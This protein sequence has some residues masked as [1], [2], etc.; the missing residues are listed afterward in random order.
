MHRAAAAAVDASSP[1]PVPAPATGPGHAEQLARYRTGL[2]V[3]ATATGAYLLWLMLGV[4]SDRLRVAV[5]DL[6]FVAAPAAAGWACLL[7]HRLRAGRHTAW[8]WL[9]AGCWTWALGSV[10]FAVYE[11]GLG[12]RTPFPSWADVGY[13]GYAVP[14]AIAIIRFP[15]ADGT[16]WARWRTAL[17]GVVIAGSLLL[18]SLVWVLEPVL[19][20]DISPFTRLDALSYP[21]VDVAVV[22][23]VMTQGLMLPH[24]RRHV[25]VPMSG[26]LLALALTDSIYVAQ[27]FGD[28]F[29]PGS[30]LDVGWLI[31]FVMVGLAALA[32]VAAPDRPGP[33]AYGEPAPMV[34]QLIPYAAVAVALTALLSDP[35]ALGS[36]GTLVA[37]VGGVL[38][39]AVVVRQVVVAAD[40]TAVARTLGD[41][42]ERRTVELRHREQWW[43]DLVQNLSDV[44]VVINADGGMRYCSPSAATTLGPWTSEAQTA[45]ELQAHIHP[46]DVQAVLDTV[47]PV[48]DGRARH[49]FVECRVEKA[50]GSWGWFEIT[51][52]G[53]LTEQ[54]L[55]G[56]VLTLHDVSERR[57]LTDQLTHEAYHDALTGLPNRALLMR[58]IEQVLEDHAGERSALL[59]IDLDDFKVI[60]DRHGHASGD[61]VLEVIGR[62][63]KNAVRPEDT[64]ARLGGDEF[65]LLMRGSTS[66]VRATADRLIEQIG[67]PVVAGGRRFLVRASVGVVFAGEDEL[68]NAHSMLSHADIALYEAKAK[69]KGGVVF[70]EGH[71][72]DAAAKQVHLREQ[73]AQPDLSQ[74]SVVYQP[75]VD[76]TTGWMRGVECLLRW[77][78][79]DLGSVPPDDFIPMAEAGGSIHV[80]G[81]Y[82]L[83]E[84]CAEL[85]R[86]KQRAPEHR[87]A[88]GVNVSSRQLDEPG[89]AARVLELVAQHDIDPSQI[90]LELTEQSLSVDFETAVTVVSDLRAGGVSVAVDDYG[91]GYSSL[92]YLHRFDA[93]VVKIDRSFIANLEGSLHTQKIVRSVMDMAIALDL[94]SIAEGIET[95]AQLALIRDLGC[96]LGQGYLFSRPVTAAEIC[97]LLAAGTAFSQ[98]TTP[99]HL[100]TR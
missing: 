28:G 53:Q 14:V 17:D 42:V 57:R 100:S 9:A 3:A 98:V 34:Q 88:V 61:L 47:R 73:I 41:A 40:H 80:L 55:Q 99:A 84:A 35:K 71:E 76:L 13:I 67:Q 82:V 27:T 43:R 83:N 20:A 81:W 77:N 25:W 21:L 60:N 91:T 44:V 33:S 10:A 90:V 65:A 26:G 79:P 56:S 96:E 89:F 11:L 29:L 15:R 70:I 87:L 62:R 46:H 8:A 54:A 52:L 48:L 16:A 69:D 7:G 31:S 63:L 97:D 66:E 85:E 32:P 50:D 6:V 78:H 64:I 94:Q 2:V 95:P 37:W 92:R 19:R 30:L 38:A 68:E 59:L 1:G 45:Q 5:S 22:S 4:G 39:V 86:W 51:A 75:I 24:A 58:R 49:G 18:T 74:F 72:R 12:D 36:H 23:L 93:D